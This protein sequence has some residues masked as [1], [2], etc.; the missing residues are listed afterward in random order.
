MDT[1]WTSD[2]EDHYDDPNDR[3]YN[4]TFSDAGCSS[5]TD[6][7]KTMKVEIKCLKSKCK[8]SAAK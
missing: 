2:D 5:A 7:S 1:N 3:L 6:P 4:G 8:C